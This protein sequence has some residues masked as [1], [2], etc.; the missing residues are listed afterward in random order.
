MNIIL[1]D[2]DL[3]NHDYVLAVRAGVIVAKKALKTGEVDFV[4]FENRTSFGVKVNK[5][6]VTVYGPQ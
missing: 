2:I 4:T 3:D 6:S 1:R 5:C